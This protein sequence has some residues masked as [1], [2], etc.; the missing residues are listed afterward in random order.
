VSEVSV[1]G[2]PGGVRACLS[3]LEGMLTETKGHA[4]AWREIPGA[5]LRARARTAG[6]PVT[7][8]DPVGG[9]D[10]FVDGRPAPDIFLATARALGAAPANAA[11]SGDALAGV[12]AGRAGG[13]GFVAGP[14]RAG[15]ASERRA[16]GAGVVVASRAGLPGAS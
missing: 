11:V 9:Y 3:G 16:H 4:A 5:C 15:Q 10:A 12:A 13:F 7:A 8:F 6:G 2:L 1:P 14:G